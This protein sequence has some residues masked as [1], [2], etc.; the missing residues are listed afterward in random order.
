MKNRD[1]YKRVAAVALSMSLVA[2]GIAPVISAKADE[3]A[4]SEDSSIADKYS[5]EG[6]HLAWHDEFNG[7]RLN[8][9]DWNVEAHEP[10]WVN[11]ELQAY[12]DET[13]S[14][15]N[16]KVSDGH[17]T[18]QPTAKKKE[19]EKPAEPEKTEEE[20]GKPK[21]I[22]KSNKFDEKNWYFGTQANG[23]GNAVYE[24]GKAIVT[25]EDSGAANYYVQL[26]QSGLSIKKGHKY[27]LSFNAKSTVARKVEINLCNPAK[28]Y[29]SYG[30]AIVDVA[31]DEKRITQ[32]FTID[33]ESSDAI[34]LQ[35]NLGLIGGKTDDSKPAVVTFSD[36]SLTDITPAEESSATASAA[37]GAAISEKKDEVSDYDITSGRINT[38]GKHDFTY[39]RF[40]ARAKV[41][42]G[43]GY[44]PAFWLMASDE[45]LYGQW[46]K[47]GEIDIMEVMGQETNKSYHTIHYG[48]N[49]GS[50]HRQ[51]QGT[52][53]LTN[54]NFA[55]DWHTYAVDWEPGKITWYVD[56]QEVYTTSDWYTGADDDSQLTYPAP[57]DQNFY[58]ILNLAVGGSWVTNPNM[59]VIEDMANQSYQVDYVRVYQKSS[60]EYAKEE[61]WEKRPV[62][63]VTYREADR[64]GNYVLNGDFSSNIADSDATNVADWQLHL[65]ADGAGTTYSIGN[66]AIT[67]NSVAAGSQNHSVQLKQGGLPMYKGWTY[68][69][70]F[71]AS[72]DQDRTIIADVEGPDNGWTRYFDDTKVKVG[73]E[74]QTYTFDFTM[75][76]KTDANGCLE[77]NLGNQGSTAPVTISNV[78]LIHK[79]GNRVPDAT[80]KTVR[81]DGNYLYNGTFDQGEN[82]LGYWDVTDK[83]AV[84]VTNN[85]NDR[86]LK[87]TVKDNP[88]T[89]GQGSLEPFGTAAYEL[90]FDAYTEDGASDGVK[91]V[92]AGKEFS[93]ELTKENRTFEYNLLTKDKDRDHS[94]IRITFSKPGTYYLDNIAIR[95]SAMI[96]NGSFDNGD[97]AFKPWVQDSNANAFGID[98]IKSG[99]NN[100]IDFS[101]KDTGAFDYSVQLKQEGITLEK[102][103]KYRLTFDGRSTLDR[104]ISAVMQQNGGDWKL[105][106]GNNTVS[107]TNDWQTFTKEFEMT[108]PT[109]TAAILN[110]NLG[111]LENKPEN[112]ITTEHHV[113]LDNFILENLSD[114]VSTGSKDTGIDV[115]DEPYTIHVEPA[116]AEPDGS[117]E[118]APE[119]VV[120]PS[121]PSTYT[122]SADDQK[123]DIDKPDDTKDPGKT[124]DTK[125][126]KTNDGK[127]ENTSDNN[128]QKDTKDDQKK[129][130]GKK[131]VTVPKNTTAIKSDKYSG[132][133]TVTKVSFKGTK[134]TSVGKNA[135]AECSN[136]KTVDLSKQKN[137]TTIGTNAFKNCK[138][139]KTIKLNANSLKKVDKKAFTGCKNAKSVKVTIYAKNKK[140]YKKVVKMLRKAGL[141][142][143]TFK[144]VKK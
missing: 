65:E 98:S 9:N 12:T 131:T 6:Y 92:S 113:Y 102:G 39:G 42:T 143:V 57:F 55:N 132:N 80:D 83:N 49:S 130:T 138:N 17:L 50:G 34:I 20:T 137:L 40:E 25:V 115:L 26:Q 61:A 64:N 58:V 105:Y 15:D 93:P 7:D 116:P 81:P 101:I 74:K 3:Q 91:V 72:S 70:S 134:V 59:D 46:P 86:R 104:Q 79:S 68:E 53:V 107:L 141:S 22:L 118:P 56:D 21:E 37:S 108:E 144:Y 110:V 8:T 121:T 27:H 30:G 73:P 129:D 44:L 28:N 31:T 66:N 112:R 54:G 88:V 90:S 126:E 63:E 82:R 69:L 123:Q 4:M 139:L 125:P 127:D 13:H 95:E 135:F 41:P 62:K 97:T 47:C 84:S 18:I 67:I 60:E 94:N 85:K 24:N 35:F 36:V 111:S 77:F 109:D 124:D 5:S 119:P 29:I 52:D 120:T 96:K 136:L 10:G 16:I 100:A 11:S 78:R 142:K 19:A 117:D 23:K 14:A 99:H 38:Q 32:D 103:K 114:D 106:S 76:G 140:Q 43:K 48:Y 2:T 87:V 122:P 33:D 71:D 1:V 89:V 51:N 75:N 45:R 128:D 133:K